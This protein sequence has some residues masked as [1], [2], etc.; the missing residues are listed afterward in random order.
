MRK[1]DSRR[2]V[3]VRFRQMA[4]DPDF[5]GR[6][7]G[8]AIM[9]HVEQSA[10]SAGAAEILG[11]VRVGNVAL[12]KRHGYVEQGEGVTLYG[13]VESVSMVRPLR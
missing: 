7:I 12:F 11:N 8:S 4:V 9:R 13:Q 10:R 6:G 5:E 1:Q 3:F 2:I